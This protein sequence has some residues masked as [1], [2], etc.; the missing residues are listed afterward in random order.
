[1]ALEEV[2]ADSPDLDV[3]GTM[4]DAPETIIQRY[5]TAF[6]RHAVAEML[7]VMDDDIQGLYPVEP[8]RNWRGKEAAGG[9]FRNFFTSYPDLKVEWRVEKTEPEPSGQ[10]VGVYMRNRLSAT[11]LDRRVHVKYVIESGR[12]KEVHHLE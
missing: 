2:L 5:F 8:H 12:I 1:M 3:R 6:T 10:A 7:E 4:T 11:G 9:V